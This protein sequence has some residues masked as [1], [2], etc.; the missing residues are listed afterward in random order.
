[1]NIKYYDTCE[2][3]HFKALTKSKMEIHMRSQ[4]TH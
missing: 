3:C 1:M 4:K 2:C